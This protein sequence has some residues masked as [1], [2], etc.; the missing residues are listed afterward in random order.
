MEDVVADEIGTAERLAPLVQARKNG[1]GVVALLQGDGNDGELL[2]DDLEQ[3][4]NHLLPCSL[5]EPIQGLPDHPVEES[6]R[7]QDLGRGGARINAGAIPGPVLTIALK[8]L[9][10]GADHAVP[11]DPQVTV[12]RKH[13]ELVVASDI[14]PTIA[15]PGVKRLD[16]AGVAVL[17]SHLPNRGHGELGAGQPLLSVDHQDWR[18][19]LHSDRRRIKDNRSTEVITRSAAQ[20]PRALEL[21]IAPE[22]VQM[23]LARPDVPSLKER[24]PIL[25]LTVEELRKAHFLEIHKQRPSSNETGILLWRCSPERRGRR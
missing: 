13:L 10:P 16:K 12:R 8:H 18:D 23:V 19:P 9:H 4:L 1:V 14:S 7:G 25:Q 5:G 22:P 11:E 17:P 20:R 2:A 3:L 21:N 24:H 6:I 15:D